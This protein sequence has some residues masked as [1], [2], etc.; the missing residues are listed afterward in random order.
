MTHVIEPAPTARAKCRGCGARIDRGELRFGERAS[1]PFGE[2]E[3]TYWFHLRCGAWR[4]P[5][6]F[7][8]ALASTTETIED[9]DTIEAQAKASIE[10]HRLPRLA[11]AQRDPSGRARCRNCKET[12]EKGAWRLLLQMWEDSRWTP[13]GFVHATCGAEYFGTHDLRDRIARMS[14][15]LTPEELAQVQAQLQR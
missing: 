14:P 10:H 2:G 1:N 13:S 4:R 7:L 5:E 11:G 3:A 8:E 15:S 9:R 6:P 12:I